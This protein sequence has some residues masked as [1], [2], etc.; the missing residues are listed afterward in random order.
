MTIAKGLASGLPI[1]GVVS[2]M[3]L[4]EEWEPGSH[5]GTFGGNAVAAAAGVATI[6]AM[7]EEGMLENAA[8]RG[9]ELFAGLRHLQEEYPQIG[10][11]RG[12]GLMIGA[13]FRT[14]ERKPDKETAKAVVHACLEERLLLL[15]CGPWDNTVRWMPPLNVSS[16]QVREALTIFNAALEKTITR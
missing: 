10:D 4:M 14:P 8:A 7:R 15:T 3:E 13:E 16:D 5:G 2:R 12:L 9:A 11:V 6:R 1:S